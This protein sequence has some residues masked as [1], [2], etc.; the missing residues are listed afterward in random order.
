ML[1]SLEGGTK[2]SWKVYGGR[3]FAGRE[4]RDEGKGSSIKYE[5]RG[6]DIQRVKN[7]IRDV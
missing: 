7:L 4:E 5:K 1:Q 3:D 2:Y 6:N